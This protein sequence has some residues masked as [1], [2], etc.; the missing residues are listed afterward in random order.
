MSVQEA[1]GQLA[2][3]WRPTD[4][5]VLNDTVVRLAWLDGTFPWHQHD[6]DELFLCWDGEF[7]IE[8]ENLAPVHLGS[9]QLF[10]VR[11]GIRHR[12]VAERRAHALLIERPATRQHGN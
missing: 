9:G 4:L 11:Q 1:I 2:G 8:L 10:V 12:P 3:P 5:A 7:R 6:E